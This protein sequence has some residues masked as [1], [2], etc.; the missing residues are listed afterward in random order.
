MFKH[1][2]YKTNHN[3]QLYQKKAVKVLSLR[4]NLKN[5]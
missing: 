3:Q 5:E 2:I 1:L 4:Q